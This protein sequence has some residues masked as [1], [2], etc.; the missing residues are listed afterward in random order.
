MSYELI[1]FRDSEKVLEDTNMLNDV[2]NTLEYVNEVLTESLYKR[3]L[4]RQALNDTD[5]TS[6]NG[7]MLIIEGRRYKWKG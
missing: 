4:F 1:H 2:K 7:D 3:E 6:P 5:W